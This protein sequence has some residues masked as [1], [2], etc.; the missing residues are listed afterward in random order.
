[1]AI[2]EQ[3]EVRQLKM[4]KGPTKKEGE[5]IKKRAKSRFDGR[6]VIVALFLATLVASLFFYLQTELPIWLERITSW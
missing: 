6:L 5:R 2:E 4:F 1:M 3:K